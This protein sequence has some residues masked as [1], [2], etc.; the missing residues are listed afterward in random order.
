MGMNAIQEAKGVLADAEKALRDIMQREL[1]AQRYAE[2]ADLAGM[3]D[4]LT[5]LASASGNGLVAKPLPTRPS[6]SRQTRPVAIQM[7][8][9]KSGSRKSYPR[10]ERIDD[11]LIKIGWSKKSREEY[12]HRAPRSAVLAF[13]EHLGANTKKDRTFVI[14][15]LLPVHDSAG[16]ELPSYQ[17]YLTLAWLRQAGAVEKR[18]RDGYVRTLEPL[19]GSTLDT[20]WDQIPDRS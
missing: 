13:T 6:G 4:G 19:D 20:L 8:R 5:R 1:K 15:Q 10:F 9:K 2:L 11:K 16:E 18:G 12:E 17:V 3:A 14:D 7:P